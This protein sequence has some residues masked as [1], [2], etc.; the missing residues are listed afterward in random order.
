MRRKKGK[1]GLFLGLFVTFLLLILELSYETLNTYEPEQAEPP[2]LLS[3]QLGDDLTQTILSAIGSAKES[4]HLS[5]FNLSDH[6]V[7]SALNKKAAE[8]VPVFLY[9]DAN[10]S[11]QGIKSLKK[12]IRVHLWKKGALMHQKILLIDQNAVYLGSANFSWRSLN[13]HRNLVLAFKSPD[14]ANFL[15]THLENSDKGKE[16]QEEFSKMIVVGGQRAKLILFPSKQDKV[17]EVQKLIDGAKKTI[18][19]AMYTWT[20]EDFAQSCAKAKQ[21]GVDVE[22]VLDRSVIQRTPNPVIQALVK[23]RVPTLIY[24]GPGLLHHKFLYVDSTKLLTGSANWTKA[25]FTQNR[26]SNILLEELTPEQKETLEKL[27]QDLKQESKL[28]Q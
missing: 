15:L 8:G 22:V 18:R 1:S 9:T 11:W 2:K 14:A 19:I 28:L 25:A 24:Q 7:I 5:V 21:R 27:W 17:R 16:F 26:E 6:K 12:N 10:A 3:A 13:I 4:V 23:G 20:R